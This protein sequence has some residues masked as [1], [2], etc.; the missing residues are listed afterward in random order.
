MIQKYAYFSVPLELLS[1]G[2]ELSFD[3]FINSSTHAIREKFVRVFPKGQILEEKDVNSFREKYHQVYVPEAQR[4]LYLN[5]IVKSENLGLSR[6]AE[7]VKEVAI[8]YLSNLFKDKKTFN[9]ELLKDTINGCKDA[10]E[11]MISVVKDIS[12]DEIQKLIGDLSFHDFYTYDHSINV[13]MYS[14]ALYRAHN[15]KASEKELIAAGMGGLLHDLGKIKIPTEI[16]N[17]PD[18]L[19]DEEFAEIMRHPKYGIDLLD[20]K[21]CQSCKEVDLDSVKRVVFEHHEN[22]NGTGYPNKLKGDDIHIMARIT[23]IADF[24]DAITT[25]RSYHEVLSAEDA[26]AVM[27]KTAGKKIDPELFKLFTTKVKNLVLKGKGNIELDES[28][29]PCQPHRVLPFVTPKAAK[30]DHDL[31]K[32]EKAYGKIVSKEDKSK[33]KAS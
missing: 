11:S 4:E 25:K 6:K 16:I 10:V 33:K 2:V 29:D 23:A 31:F 30:K 28:F 8:H 12:I 20:T 21:V 17:N 22:F 26:L 14:I 3:L 24:F 18:K 13:A 5:S 19:T 27:D 32:K 1:V 9:T 7:A 15:P